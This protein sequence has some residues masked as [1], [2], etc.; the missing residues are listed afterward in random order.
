MRTSRGWHLVYVEDVDP[1]QLAPLDLIRDRVVDLMK[2]DA[3]DALLRDVRDRTAVTVV[4]EQL[5]DI[6]K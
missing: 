5:A 6:L 1:G 4:R 3:V 2:R